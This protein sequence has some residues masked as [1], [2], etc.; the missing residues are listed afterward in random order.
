MVS[1]YRE[2]VRAEAIEKLWQIQI[3][4]EKGQH[5]DQVR[6]EE[7][8]MKSRKLHRYWKGRGCDSSPVLTLKFHGKDLTVEIVLN[9]ESLASNVRG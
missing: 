4:N 5:P 1:K 9:C 3:H 7:F 2:S 6:V 8:Q